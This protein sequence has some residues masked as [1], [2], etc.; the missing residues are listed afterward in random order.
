MS[1]IQQ[2]WLVSF[3]PPSSAHRRAALA[4]STFLLV[5]FVIAV[6][7]AKVM[8]PHLNIY[9]PLVATVMFLNDL[10]TASLLL[11]QFSIGR[12][13]TLL[14]L[15]NGYLFTALVVAAYGLVWPGAFHPTGLFGAGP[16]TQP[17]LYLI[18]HA[19]LPI[20]VII[21]ALL[22]GKEHKTPPV[23]RDSVRKLIFAS[24]T[25]NILI[26]CGLT[27]FVTRFQDILPVLVTSLDRSSEF[28]HV[29]RGAIL[30]LSIGAFGLQWRRRLQSALDL[31]LSVVTL[32]WL[33]GSIM[34]NAIGA[35]YDVAWYATTGFSVVSATFVLLILLSESLMLHAQLDLTRR[36]RLRQLEAD[37]AH[38]NRLSIM[39]ELAA[40]LAHEVKQPIATARNN[41]R[42]AM[43]FLD[44]QPPEL[45]EVRE[46]VG[47]IVGDADRAGDI[48]DRIRDH[49]KKTPP[50]RDHFDLTEAVKEVIILAHGAITKN[51]VSV[52]TRLAERLLSVQG[53]RVQLQQ[54]VLNLV[55]NAVEAMGSVEAGARE[56]LISTEMRQRGGVLVSLRDSGPGIDPEDHERVFEAFYT[57]KSAGVGMG[58]SICRSIIEAHGGRLWADANDPRGAVFQFTL[59]NAE[60]ELMSSLRAS[61][62]IKTNP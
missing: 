50:R 57:T 5:A 4:V 2:P 1:E 30:F 28:S 20:S 61:T 10:L 16:Q 38:M 47:C 35:R 55:L 37:L 43:N 3:L 51:G 7:S 48:I 13:R 23:T 40:S 44:R 53:D 17:W 39:G 31:W 27:W 25:C 8:L 18:W 34:L 32:A 19:G 45:G 14:L 22:E 33:L 49:I 36:E 42:A 24:T 62:L 52:Q 54:V 41:A 60:T 29:G 46:A 26:V 15:A 9:I 56:L 21:Y 58:L 59:P 6:P 11:A 12:S